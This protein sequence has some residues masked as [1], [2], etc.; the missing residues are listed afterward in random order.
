GRFVARVIE[1]RLAH[2]A[3]PTFR[4]EDRGQ[5]ATIGRSSAVGTVFGTKLRGFTAWCAWLGIHILFLIEVEH[6]LLVLTQWL[7]NCVTF[8]RSARLITSATWREASED[9]TSGG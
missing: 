7:W 2:R 5:L 1:A 9:R 4:F 6:G 3:T 8:S